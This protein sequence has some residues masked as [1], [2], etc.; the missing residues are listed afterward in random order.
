MA[1]KK[2]NNVFKITCFQDENEVT[3]SCMQVEVDG[4]K[5]LLDFGGYQDSR[6]TL[7]KWIKKNDDKSGVDLASVDYVCISHSNLDHIMS[8]SLCEKLECEFNGKIIATALTSELSHHILRDATKIHIS[9]VKKYNYLNGKHLQPLYTEEDCERA[10]AMIQ[11]YSYNQVI[12]LSDT[13]DVELYP[14]GHIAGS[15][16]IYLTHHGEYKDTHLMYCPD[17]YLG[18]FPRGYT[19]SIIKKCYKAQCV[20]LEATYGDKP[21]H[22]KE[23]PKDY[24]EQVILEHVIKNKK[25]LFIPTFSMQRSTQ[26]VK[27]LD[28]IYKTNEVIRKANVPIYNCGKLTKLCHESIGKN[29]YKEFY[30]DAWNEDR[31]VFNNPICKFITDPKDVEHFV[32]NNQP[33]IC[34]S[35]AGS[36]DAGFSNM[37]MESFVGNKTVKILGCG[38]IF[39]DSVL[40]RVINNKSKVTING[41]GKTKRCEFL[42]II[43]NLS[44]HVDLENNIKWATKY[45]DQR[46]LKKVLIVHGDKSAR[47]NLKRELELRMKDKDIIIPTYGQ[48]IKL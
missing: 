33:K 24:L 37:I 11:G 36:C 42:G 18:D 8:L 4:L 45:F 48:I 41:M 31:D 29:E 26:I 25:Q 44:G 32:L 2:D 35:S 3:G 1:K 39:K 27:L 15:A 16:L 23:S 47:E 30:D 10:L 22:P 20:I 21:N 38:H 12:K 19:K 5:I 28:E 7:D 46:V 9:D 34:L 6:Y 43:P 40:D 14:S 17:M 13:V